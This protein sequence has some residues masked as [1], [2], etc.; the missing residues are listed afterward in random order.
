MICNRYGTM[1]IIVVMVRAWIQ[2][3]SL[4]S[5]LSSVHEYFLVDMGR[6]ACY[7][8]QSVLPSISLCSKEP[9][10][11]FYETTHYLHTKIMFSYMPLPSNSCL[12]CCHFKSETN[13]LYMYRYPLPLRRRPRT[14]RHSG[15]RYSLSPHRQEGS[16]S[17]N[18]CPT[19]L[20]PTTRLRICSKKLLSF[21]IEEGIGTLGST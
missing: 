13:T 3:K 7:T 4:M 6:L 17:S 8:F 2:E 12:R 5:V 11:L 9:L 21:A 15:M 14:Q 20:D 16:E 1:H 18:R 19:I 10:H